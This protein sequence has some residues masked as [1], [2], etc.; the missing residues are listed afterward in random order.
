VEGHRLKG[1]PYG[2]ISSMFRQFQNR[3]TRGPL[4]P[5]GPSTQ[6][7]YIIGDERDVVGLRG[8]IWEDPVYFYSARTTQEGKRAIL[9]DMMKHAHS[10][11]EDFQSSII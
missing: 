4:L 5:N 10:L 11:E 2:V 9:V 7:I 3:R 1:R 6:L 8:A